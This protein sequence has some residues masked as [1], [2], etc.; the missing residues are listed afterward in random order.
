M[1]HWR[2]Q[3]LKVPPGTYMIPVVRID[4]DRHYPATFSNK[5]FAML[6]DTFKQAVGMAHSAELQIDFDALQSERPFYRRLI[7]RL[8]SDLPTVKISITCLASWCLFDRWT[9]GLPVNETVP[10]MFSLAADRQAVLIYFRSQHDFLLSSSLKSLGLSLEDPEINALMI[11]IARQ[12]KIPVRIYVF[13][14]TAWNA[15]K[16]QTLQSLLGKS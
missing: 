15:K 14:R 8:A 9:D 4:V 11:P 1:R 10:M 2:D 3:P 5:Q 6:V 16:L 12:R 7:E 13:T